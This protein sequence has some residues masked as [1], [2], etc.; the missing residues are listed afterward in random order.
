MLMEETKQF[1]FWIFLVFTINTILKFIFLSATLRI[2]HNDVDF[3]GHILQISYLPSHNKD[4]LNF[5][6]LFSLFI[7]Q[8]RILPEIR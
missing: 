8:V 3:P 1:I 5:N 2:A 4:Y 7:F 6:P